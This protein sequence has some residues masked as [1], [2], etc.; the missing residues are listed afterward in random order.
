MYM[1]EPKIY[2]Q[3][4]NSE[5]P[6][7]PP[8]RL[9]DTLSTIGVILLAPI[10]ALILTQFVF[11]SY[12]VDGPSMQETLQDHD[13]LIVTK[14]GKSWARLTG[15]DYIPKRYEI[16]IFNHSGEFGNAVVSEKQLVKRVIGLPGDRVLVKDGVVTIYNKENP[17]G[18][19]IDRQG[20]EKNTI[21]TT[22]GEIDETI[23]DGELYVMGDNRNNS[24]DSR[25]FGAIRSHDVV[26]RLS[27]RIYPF[28]KF[29]KF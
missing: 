28:D 17:K 13:R 23:K 9:N 21:S 11:Q 12:Q 18:F 29:D 16:I 27:L 3:E 22:P 24:L 2:T 5:H 10:V 6:R 8:S 19:L 4:D 26:G 20:P 7:R 15:K 1:E 14:T 25:S